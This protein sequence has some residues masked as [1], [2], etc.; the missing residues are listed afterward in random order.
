M[1]NRAFHSLQDT[2]TTL[3]NSLI[4]VLLNIALNLILV[5]AM[6]VGGLALATSLSAGVGAA[7]LL[8][9]LRKKLGRIGGRESLEELLKIGVGTL[10]CALVCLFLNRL[11]PR[12]YGA[13]MIFL[14]LAVCAGVP[15]AAYGCIEY[16]LGSR[17]VRTLYRLAARRLKRS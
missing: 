11:L 12:A 16:L 9:R 14:R 17:Q 2:R 8:V 5:R 13:G 1:L 6:G 4:T 15:L 10:C 7:L 3:Y